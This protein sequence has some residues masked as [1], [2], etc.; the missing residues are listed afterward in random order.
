MR[1]FSISSFLLFL[2]SLLCLLVSLPPT[3]IRSDLSFAS[4][5]SLSLSR[6][7]SPAHTRYNRV[8]SVTVS[9]VTVDHARNE[10]V[11]EKEERKG[12]THS[13]SLSSDFILS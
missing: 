6:F 12:E 10:N 11:D 7:L 13:Q 1:F 5:P 2:F 3:G 9:F 4:F 8:L